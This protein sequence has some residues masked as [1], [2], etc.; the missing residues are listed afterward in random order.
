MIEE[1]GALDFM[2]NPFSMPQGGL[3]AILNTPD[4]LDIPAYQYDIVCNGFEL[5]SGGVRNNKIELM[6]EVF[7]KVGY[8]KEAVDDK[9]GGMINAFKYGAPPHA[10][11]APGI[12]RVVMLLLD[13]ENLR[14][15]TAFP[16]NGKGEDLMM[17]APNAASEIQLRELHIKLR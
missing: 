6:Y 13:E 14:E 12:D 4:P 2:H 3:E 7:R 17:N 11:C 8:S 10:G 1:T 16:T 15:V 5:A 9:F